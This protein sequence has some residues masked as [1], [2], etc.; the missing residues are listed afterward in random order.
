MNNLKEILLS[1]LPNFREKSLKFLNGDI[2]KPEYK[3]F[4]GGYGVYAQRDKKSFMIRL[5]LHVVYFQNLNFIL[6]I[7][8]LMKI[9]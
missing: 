3:G 2:S 8:W 4:S 9:N 5:E 6:Y 1:E 7:I